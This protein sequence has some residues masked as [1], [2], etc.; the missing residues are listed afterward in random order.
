MQAVQAELCLL[1]LAR[2]AQGSD[3]SYSLMVGPHS[4]DGRATRQE[5]VSLT[6]PRC[7]VSPDLLGWGVE[8]VRDKV[9]CLEVSGM[10]VVMV[11]VVVQHPS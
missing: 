2:G 8:G 7:Q 4:G 11:V 5:S 3:R 6:S 10:V 9:H 1:P